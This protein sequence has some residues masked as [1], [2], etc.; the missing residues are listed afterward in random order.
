MYCCA[1]GK[2]LIIKGEKLSKAQCTHNDDARGQMKMGPYASMIG[3]LMYAP[4]C[5]RPNIAFAVGMLGRY[6]SDPGTSH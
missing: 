3:S 2:A 6:L 1:L 4:I 5:T